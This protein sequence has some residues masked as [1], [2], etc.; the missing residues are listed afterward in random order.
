VPQVFD[1]V[2]RD[3]I[4]ELHVSNLDE[5][6]SDRSPT[7]FE[8]EQLLAR[9]GNRPSRLGADGVRRLGACYRP[10][11]QAPTSR[12]E[13]HASHHSVTSTTRAC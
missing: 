11:G 8:L 12:S 9:A 5:F 7:W 2:E 1:H 4:V 6:V 3:P 10:S 13:S